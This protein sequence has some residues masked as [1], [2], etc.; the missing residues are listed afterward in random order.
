MQY[1][2]DIIV[3]SI[4]NIPYNTYGYIYNTHDIWNVYIYMYMGYHELIVFFL[5]AR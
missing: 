4:Y 5:A 3:M 2:Y 1:I